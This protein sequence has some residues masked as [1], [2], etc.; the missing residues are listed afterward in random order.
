MSFHLYILVTAGHELGTLSIQIYDSLTVYDNSWALKL[1]S[2][3]EFQNVISD[4]PPSPPSPSVIMKHCVQKWICDSPLSRYS[5]ISIFL[6]VL[7]VLCWSFYLEEIMSFFAILLE[8]NKYSF[9]LTF[10]WITSCSEATGG[11]L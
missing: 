8:K 5:P 11:V 4:S 1:D 7:S 9:K 6:N 10:C 2:F 3:S